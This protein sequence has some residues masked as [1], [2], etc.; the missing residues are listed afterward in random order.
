MKPLTPQL[1]TRDL[2]PIARAV[3]LSL[4]GLGLA[5]A[6]AMAATIEVTSNADDGAGALCTLREA[7]TSMNTAIL[8]GDC[9]YYMRVSDLYVAPFV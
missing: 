7:V 6:S 2:K 8:S 1:K 9:E 4:L 5:H 3:K